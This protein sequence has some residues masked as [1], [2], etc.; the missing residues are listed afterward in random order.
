MEKLIKNWID[1]PKKM[2][3][4]K[5]WTKKL[6]ELKKKLDEKCNEPKTKIGR[7]MQRAKNKNWTEFPTADL[8]LR[9]RPKYRQRRNQFAREGRAA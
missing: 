6:D 4:Q 9:P 5:K 2:D 3:E 8:R 7:K 1:C